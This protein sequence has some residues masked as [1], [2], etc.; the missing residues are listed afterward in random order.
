M[1]KTKRNSLLTIIVFLLAL[2]LG[3]FTTIQGLGKHHIGQ[4]KNIILGLDLAGG[5]SITYRIV[6]EDPTAQEISDTKTRLQQRADVYSTDSSVYQEGTDRFSIEI[7]GVSDA[8][9][10]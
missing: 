1:R 2:V 10:S 3:A 7:P 8:N 9:K 4:A 6:D 5:V